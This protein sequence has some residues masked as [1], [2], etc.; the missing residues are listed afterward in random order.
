MSRIR[1]ALIK[2]ATGPAVSNPDGALTRTFVFPSDFPGF[3]GHFPGYPILPAVVQIEAGILL[4]EEL[5]AKVS[6]FSSVERAKFQR[7]INPDKAVQV[8]CRM[9]PDKPGRFEVS[10]NLDQGMASSFVLVF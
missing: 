3:D 1:Q 8:Q 5:G 4:A 2:A 9:A 10:L 6:S 7:E